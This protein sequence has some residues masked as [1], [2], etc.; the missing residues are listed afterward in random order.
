M[1]AMRIRKGD[2]SVAEKLQHA[3]FVVD[4]EGKEAAAMIDYSLYEE[5]LELL[6]D[7]E[8][9]EELRRLRETGE[10]PLSW[11]EAKAQLRA[12]GVEV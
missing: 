3:K 11:E 1:D 4:A 5:L 8:D 10:E 2:V 6:G 7:A 9:A 12:D